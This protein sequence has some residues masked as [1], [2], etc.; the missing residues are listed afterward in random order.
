LKLSCTFVTSLGY[1][2]HSCDS[3]GHHLA[4]FKS[5][6][7]QYV[8]TVDSNKT[9][10]L[11]CV[12]SQHDCARTLPPDIFIRCPNALHISP[13]VYNC[14]DLARGRDQSADRGDE[15][16]E[17]NQVEENIVLSSRTFSCTFTDRTRRTGESCKLYVH[18]RIS[19]KVSWVH[20]AEL[21]SFDVNQGF[22]IL[23]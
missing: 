7:F 10:S 19:K 5:D 16:F 2:Y 6:G 18:L 15:H 14:C 21:S 11:G 3:V 13:D 4:E 23:G 20:D 8:Q 1:A 9:E 12:H 22:L 17:G